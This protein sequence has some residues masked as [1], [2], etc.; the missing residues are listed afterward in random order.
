[1]VKLAVAG[2]QESPAPFVARARKWYVTPLFYYLDPSRLIGGDYAETISRL[3]P[4]RIWT[5]R[6]SE[7]DR[8]IEIDNALHGFRV[9]QEVPV[10]GERILLHV[11]A[12]HDDTPSR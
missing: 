1:M 12:P 4:A 10:A 5:I 2:A 9:I 11:R 7:T 3:E 8:G 6:F